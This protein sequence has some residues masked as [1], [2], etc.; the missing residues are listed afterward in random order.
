[1][2]GDGGAA[3]RQLAGELADRAAARGDPPEGG[4]RVRR[5]GAAGERVLARCGPRNG[6]FAARCFACRRAAVEREPTPR[7]FSPKNQTACVT[8][9]DISRSDFSALP[10]S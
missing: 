4:R 1:M 9:P 8:A 6:S 10:L 5:T 2:L 7:R 3:D